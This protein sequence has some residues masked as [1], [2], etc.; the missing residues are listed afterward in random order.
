MGTWAGPNTFRKRKTDNL[1]AMDVDHAQMDPTKC[2][3]LMKSR[4]CFHYKKQEHMAKDY[5]Q[6]QSQIQEAATSIASKKK[7]KQRAT[8][9]KKKPPAYNTI[10][11]QINA[12][13]ME[14]CQKLL[15]FF[16]QDE[17][18]EQDF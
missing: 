4:S 13:S 3:K 17:D 16:K 18:E 1:D 9:D 15:E 2:K 8:N 12:C 10:I 11:K 5:P 6:K 7:D 14:N